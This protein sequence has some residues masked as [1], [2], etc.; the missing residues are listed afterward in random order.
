VRLFVAG[1]SG[2]IGRPLVAQLLAAGHDVTGMTRSPDAARALEQI[3][4]RLA[5]ADALDPAA[6]RAAVQRARPEVVVEQ[7]TALPQENTPQARQQAAEQHARVRQEGG[8]SLQAAARAAGARRY[9]AQSSAFWC[10]PGRGLADETVPLLSNGPPGLVAAASA[11]AALEERVLSEPV[12]ESVVLRYGFF[13]GPRTWYAVDGSMADQVRRQELPIVG[14][15]AGV[16]SFVHVED[17][18]AATVSAAERA[19]TGIFHVVDD[20][21]TAL[22]DWLPAFARRLRAPAP[23]EV[24]V[25]DE[26][27]AKDPIGVYYATELRGAANALAREELSYRPRPLEWLAA[28]PLESLSTEL[29]PL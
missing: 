23:R 12:M 29:L 27:L 6:V 15:G 26:L 19:V 25:T 2:A 8:A 10:S 3:G 28:E 18:A 21:P 17:A 24:P 20:H 5:L 1:A 16:W 11:L 4:A 22:R 7:L 13:Y 14:D 9:V